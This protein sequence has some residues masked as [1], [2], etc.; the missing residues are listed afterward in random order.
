MRDRSKP[1]WLQD[2]GHPVIEPTEDEKKAAQELK[3]RVE[4]AL[5]DSLIAGLVSGHDE[6]SRKTRAETKD[7]QKQ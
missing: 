3:N 5:H 4:A 6:E 7:Q 1:S 2:W